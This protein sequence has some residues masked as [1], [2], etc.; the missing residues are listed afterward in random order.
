VSLPV[1]Y[2]DDEPSLCRVFELILDA[3]GI[4]IATFRDP[5]AAI[6]YLNDRDVAVVFCDYR[7]PKMTGLTVLAK[8]TRPAPFYLVSGDLAAEE[9][10]S[11]AGVTGLL[12]K[13]FRPEELVALVEK[14]VGPAGS[15]G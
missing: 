8:M 1:V 11:T 3:R 7:M 9:C 4:E 5:V 14:H 6:A 15:T 2:I 12:A 10:K 13:P